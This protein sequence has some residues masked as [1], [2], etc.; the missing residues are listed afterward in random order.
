M[1]VHTEWDR[2]TGWGFHAYT[3][4]SKPYNPCYN[5]DTLDRNDHHP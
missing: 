4:H 5:L 1:W 3:M 2:D